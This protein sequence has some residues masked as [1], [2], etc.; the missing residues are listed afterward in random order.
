VQ[1]GRS[2]T[3]LAI[4]HDEIPATVNAADRVHHQLTRHDHSPIIR[5]RSRGDI[6]ALR[7]GYDR[8]SGDAGRHFLWSLGPTRQIGVAAVG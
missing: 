8:H 5:A 6:A 3:L 2:M 4:T 1:E 7:C